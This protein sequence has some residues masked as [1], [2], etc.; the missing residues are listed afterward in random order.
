MINQARQRYIPRPKP[1]FKD[2]RPTSVAAPAYT[3]PAAP[4]GPRV[5]RVWENRNN[6]PRDTTGDAKSMDELLMIR[7]QVAAQVRPAPKADAE[8]N[9]QQTPKGIGDSR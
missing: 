4:S 1:L 6:T 7:A 5:S 2:P 9:S 8:E 3:P